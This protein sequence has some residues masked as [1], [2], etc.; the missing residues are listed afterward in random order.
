MFGKLRDRLDRFKKDT[1]E[2]LSDGIIKPSNVPS[3]DETVSADS[4]S[5]TP[6][7]I[8]KGA[9]KF[10]KRKKKTNPK[11]DGKTSE[12]EEQ[13]KINEKKLD[14]ILWNLETVLLE[15]DVSPEAIENIKKNTRKLLS[16]RKIK[17]KDLRKEIESV[18]KKAIMRSFPVK[19][20]VFD[21]FIKDIKKPAVILFVGINGTGKTTTIA[22]MANFIKKKGYSV[23]LAAA[24]TFRAGA[25]DQ[26][27]IHADNIGVKIIK[28]QGG[29]DAAAVAYDAVQH[30]EARKKDFVFIDSAGRMQTNSNLMDEIRKIK[31]VTNAGYTIFVGDALAGNDMVEQAKK[32]QEHIGIDGIILSKID[33]DAKGGAALSVSIE[34]G[35][36]IM[37]FG[38]GQNY[39][40]LLEFNASW[41]VKHIF[42]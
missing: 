12:D 5:S 11:K 1:E 7:V 22:K 6:R 42:D 34:T 40:D 4:T 21:E 2:E 9:G 32:F 26:L 31:R 19:K 24:D 29:G 38:T 17:R 23:I 36:P 25:I 15:S 10:G 27:Q 28:H 16:G 30:A 8:K 33:T 37:F 39:D 13:L 20:F 14:N 41:F 18:L 35:K 3:D